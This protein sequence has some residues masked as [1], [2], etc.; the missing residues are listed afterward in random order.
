[1]SGR[2][3]VE[4]SHTCLCQGCFGTRKV[5]VSVVPAVQTRKQGYRAREVE[6]K[7]A[8]NVDDI[9]RANGE[10]VASRM[11]SARVEQETEA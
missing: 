1:M 11:F 3:N 10:D 7:N 8:A 5:N 4:S 9:S 2:G 6:L